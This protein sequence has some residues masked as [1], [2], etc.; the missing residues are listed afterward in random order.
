[1]L[2]T[3]VVYI[4]DCQISHNIYFI[5]TMLLSIHLSIFHTQVIADVETVII[6]TELMVK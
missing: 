4:R 6:K 3:Y 1:M 2:T 5:W